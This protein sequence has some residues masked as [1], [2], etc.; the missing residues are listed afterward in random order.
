MNLMKKTI[1]SSK[2]FKPSHSLSLSSISENCK[3]AKCLFLSP[4]PDAPPPPL[5]SLSLTAPP[6]KTLTTA[7]IALSCCRTA[8][9]YLWIWPPLV[10]RLRLWLPQGFFLFIFSI[11]IFS[12]FLILFFILFLPMYR[13][14][15][16]LFKAENGD[17]GQCL[18]WW[19]SKG[20]KNSK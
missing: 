2:N 17:V 10:S 16:F 15:F 6:T 7:P 14:I 11:F 4:M 8:R 1:L 12:T 19:R 18:R 3:K 9:F 13:F 5:L 20:I